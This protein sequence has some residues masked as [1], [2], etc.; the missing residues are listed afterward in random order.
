MNGTFYRRVVR[1]TLKV[2]DQLCCSIQPCLYTHLIHVVIVFF[3]IWNTTVLQIWML[4]QRGY[5]LYDMGAI[6][7]YFLP[8]PQL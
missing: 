7:I 6:Y 3:L 2:F 5:R 1:E 8:V 4:L